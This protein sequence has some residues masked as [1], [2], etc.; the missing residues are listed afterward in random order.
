MTS[1]Y[2]TLKLKFVA[3]YKPVFFAQKNSIKSTKLYCR[4]FI[5]LALFLEYFFKNINFSYKIYFFKKTKHMNSILKAP[6]HYKIAQTKFQKTK[7]FFIVNLLIFQNCSFW[8]FFN[9][10][11]IFNS[12]FFFNSSL[13]NIFNKQIKSSQKLFCLDLF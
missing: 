1:N 12:F 5:F 9:F 7:F 13:I 10:I 8:C 3:N 2:L 6:H 11:N 4:Y